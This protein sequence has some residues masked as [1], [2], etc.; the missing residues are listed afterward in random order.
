MSPHLTFD[1]QIEIINRLPVKSLLQFRSVCKAWK[2]LID[3]SHFIAGYNAPPDQ[4]QHLMMSYKVREEEDNEVKYVGFVD[5]NTTFPQQKFFL[6]I[7]HLARE[8]I[9]IGSSHGLFCFKHYFPT[10]GTEIVLLWNPAIRKSIAI[11]VPNEVHP[12]FHYVIGFGVCPHTKDP[13]LVKVTYISHYSFMGRRSCFPCQQVMVFTLSSG[14][15]RTSRSNLVPRKSIEFPTIASSHT[16][17]GQFIY[18]FAVDG[19]KG[20]RNLIM[21]FDLSTDEFKEIHLPNGLRKA[22]L[23]IS[24]LRDSLVLLDRYSN[25]TTDKQV[26]DVWMMEHGDPKAFTKLYTI[27]SPDASVLWTEGFRNNGEPIIV[28]HDDDED[29]D[30]FSQCALVVYEPC[31]EHIMDLGIRGPRMSISSGNSYTYMESLLLLNHDDGHIVE[32]IIFTLR[33]DIPPCAASSSNGDSLNDSNGGD[34]QQVS[35]ADGIDIEIEKL[36]KNHRRIPSKIAVQPSLQTL[37]GIWS[38]Y[39]PVLGRNLNRRLSTPKDTMQCSGRE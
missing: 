4:P 5:D 11:V 6:T 25:S 20:F 24:R 16:V 30:V 39:K 29:E 33:G 23:C 7:P 26:C 28:M 38:S 37:W 9:V 8:A 12:P 18:W 19:T 27:K 2:S 3:S 15:W 22:F 17:I 35:D 21:S 32:V 36:S 10:F 1:L 13:K 34:L 31:L 14:K